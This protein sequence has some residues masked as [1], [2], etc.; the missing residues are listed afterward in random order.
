MHTTK[1][2]NKCTYTNIQK[3]KTQTYTQQNTQM[4]CP[5]KTNAQ[6]KNA[7]KQKTNILTTK[8]TNKTK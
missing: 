2:K 1:H 6:T 7:Q 5:P 4:K 3:E 8:H